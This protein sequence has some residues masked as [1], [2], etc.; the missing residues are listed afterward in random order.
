MI[1]IIDTDGS[2]TIHPIAY[3][4]WRSLAQ[5]H[6]AIG[7]PGMVVVGPGIDGTITITPRPVS[8]AA[9]EWDG[10]DTHTDDGEEN[11]APRDEAHTAAPPK[12]D[13]N[14]LVDGVCPICASASAT[15][16]VMACENRP[17]SNT[18]PVKPARKPRAGFAFVDLDALRSKMRDRAPWS[19]AQLCYALDCADERSMRF[20]LTEIG[21]VRTGKARGTRYSLPP[22]AP[23][24]GAQGAASFANGA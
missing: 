22:Q 6:P 19:M 13:S 1:A 18:A 7:F 12:P 23:E 4:A 15:D 10:C 17:A 8:S 24:A 2:I 11:P 14:G 20:A 9:G 16:H 21:A 5:A 3:E